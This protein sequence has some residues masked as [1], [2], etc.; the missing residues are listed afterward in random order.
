M[1][2]SSNRDDVYFKASLYEHERS[3]GVQNV[4]YK[5]FMAGYWYGYKMAL[6]KVRGFVDGNYSEAVRVSEGHE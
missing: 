2:N 3:I 1:E 5:E 4:N 6:N